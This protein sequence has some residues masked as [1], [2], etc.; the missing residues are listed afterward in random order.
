MGGF[1]GP[2]LEAAPITPFT[3][4]QLCGHIQL[5]ESLKNAVYLCVQKEEEMGLATVCNIQEA[6]T[7][8]SGMN[9]SNIGD[10]TLTST[11]PM[12]LGSCDVTGSH[13]KTLGFKSQLPSLYSGPARAPVF[14]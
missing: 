6:A 2:D 5:Q 1:Y 3:L 4:H 7:F 11:Q 14:S 12:M 13:P 8:H 10:L 9:W